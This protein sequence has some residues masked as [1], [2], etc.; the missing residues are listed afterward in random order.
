MVKSEIISELKVIYP[1]L[2]TSQIS[3]IFDII[4]QTISKSLILNQPVELRNFGRWSIRVLKAK[5][6][7][8]NPKTQ[9]LIFVPERKKIIFKMS[10]H[11]KNEIN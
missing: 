6:N 9:E 3:Y 1:N 11:L 10:K 5:K 7:A 2:K 4:F 8:R